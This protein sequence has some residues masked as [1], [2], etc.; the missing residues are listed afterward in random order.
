MAGRTMPTRSRLGEQELKRTR[1]ATGSPFRLPAKLLTPT[2]TDKIGLVERLRRTAL[3][4]AYLLKR[5]VAAGDSQRFA[6]AGR[7]AFRADVPPEQGVVDGVR[8]NVVRGWARRRDGSADL[9]YVDAYLD[10]VFVGRT[11]CDVLRDDLAQSGQFGSGRHGFEFDLAAPLTWRGG[12]LRIVA[13]ASGLELD[14]S[15]LQIGAASADP[16]TLHPLL[17]SLLGI[18]ASLGGATSLA[19]LE[20]TYGRRGQVMAEPD[21]DASDAGWPVSRAM[22]YVNARFHGGFLHHHGH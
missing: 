10:E 3:I 12:E 14:G 16:E 13:A 5:L 17:A 4:G 9:V 11:A 8:E 20:R 1:S 21:P 7:P 6:P 22:A 19:D 15:P 18:D 2:G